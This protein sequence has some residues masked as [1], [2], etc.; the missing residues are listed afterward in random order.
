M[1]NKIAAVLLLGGVLFTF[2]KEYIWI[3]IVII[4][5]IIIIRIIADIYWWFKDKNDKNW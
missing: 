3:P 2:L 1:I 4:I 5:G